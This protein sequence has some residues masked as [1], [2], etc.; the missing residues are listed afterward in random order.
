MTGVEF[1]CT[2]C[3][4][5]VFSAASVTPPAHGSCFTCVFLETTIPD[6]EER[7]RVRAFLERERRE[8]DAGG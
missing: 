1:T 5:F 8:D 7:Q 6:P 4:A 3:G 2:S